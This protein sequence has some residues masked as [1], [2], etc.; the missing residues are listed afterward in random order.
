MTKPI[1]ETCTQVA[2]FTFI[3][4]YGKQRLLK[5]I[6]QFKWNRPAVGWFKLNTDGSSLGN[7]GCAGGG[8]IIRN[9]DGEWVTG[10][11]RD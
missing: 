5:H 9:A 11:N 7:P 8:G 3:G 6:I 4:S 10:Y 2:K 1:S